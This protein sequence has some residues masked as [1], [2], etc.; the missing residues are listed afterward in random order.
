MYY[1]GECV[2]GHF[3]I[4]GGLVHQEIKRLESDLIQIDQQTKAE[5]VIGQV[6]IYTSQTIKRSDHN[7]IPFRFTLPQDVGPSSEHYS[8]RFKTRMIC[9]HG[10]TRNDQDFIHIEQKEGDYYDK[11]L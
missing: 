11:A 7:E 6:T 2:T 9:Q 3:C 4:K 1:P 10:T 8:Y 5:Q